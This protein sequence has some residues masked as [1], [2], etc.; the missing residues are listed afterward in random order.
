MANFLTSVLNAGIQHDMPDYL[1][2]RVKPTNI[3]CLVVISV[4][5]IPFTIISLVYFPL[6]AIFPSGAG[7]V[8]ILI[9]V[10]NRLG[11]I[12][13][14]RAVLPIL[15]LILSSL[16]N[17][18]F[19]TSMDDAITSVYLVE[20]SFVLIPFIV[21]DF[22]EKGF[23]IVCNLF[24]LFII[25][26]FPL[27]WEY[28]DMGYDGTVL[29]EGP[30][31]YL[32]IG[33]ATFSQIGSITGLAVLNRQ[34]ESRSTELFNEV[35]KEK[36]EALQSRKELESNLKQLE[37]ARIE[38]NNRQWAAEGIA[39]LSETLRSHGEEK[40]IYDKVIAMIVKYV[41]A[42]QGGLY[43]AD[44]TDS[45]EVS[46][47]LA[48]CYAYERKK[49]IEQ[50]FS[51][52]QG[53]LGQAYL[54]KEYIYLTEI[55]QNYIT[56]T[57]GLGEARP[58]SLLVMPLKVNDKIEGM[59]ELASFKKFEPYQISFIEKLAENL[60]GFIQSNRIN[61]QTKKLLEISQQ[62]AEEMRATEEEMRQ[63]MEEL[64]ATQEE[65]KRKSAEMEGQIMAIDAALA[66]IEF[67]L[68]GTVIRANEKFLQ[69]MGY[70]LG[71]IQGKHH[72]MFIDAAYAQSEEYQQFWQHLNE[73]KSQIGD[74]MRISKK[75]TQ[76]WLKAS[77]SPAYDVHGQ[78]Y[79]IVKFAQD[80]TEQRKL[81]QEVD[82]RSEQMSR[83]ISEIEAQTN[84]VN[85]VAIVSK[86]DLQGNI[87]YVNEEFL[88][89]S[90]YTREEVM[91]RNHRFLK[92]GEQDDKLFEELWKTISSG[93]IFRG[94]I[95][96]KAKDG[97]F[98]WVDAIIAPV[99]DENGKPKEYIA[100]RFV[101]NEV[102]E[103]EA[104]VAKAM[105][106]M[107]RAQEEMKLLGAEMQAQNA[108]INNIAIVSKTDLQ[109][110]ITYVNDEFLKWSKYTLQ[111]VIGKNH[112]IL[113][114]GDQ[115]D[116]IFEELWKTISSGKTF[117]GEIKN[118]AKDGSFYWVDAI[119]APIFDE[120]GKPKEYIAQRFVINEAKEKEAVVKAQTSIINSI[121]IVSKTD[122]QGNIT[123]VNDEF[124]KWSKYTLQE[125]IGKNHRILK[126]GDQ[127]DA[128]FEELWKTI[129]SGKIFRGQIKNKA[130]DGTFYWVD[131]I[132]APVLDE[133][134][135]PKEYIA[136]RFVI[137]EVK[138]KEIH[139]AQ[140]ME[141]AQV[142]EKEIREHLQSMQAGREQ[143]VI[144][145]NARGEIE[146]INEE[147]IKMT[148][149]ELA[150]LAGKRPGDV[151]QGPDTDPQ[152]IAN[153]R[154]ALEKRAV[155]KGKIINYSK[156]G[157]PLICH[158]TL[159]PVMNAMGKVD[160]FVSTA[161][162]IELATMESFEIRDN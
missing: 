156:A 32:A 44:T 154:K 91:G 45:G 39:K 53:L 80:T 29:R 52:G 26:I 144:L 155:F 150:D 54:E 21:F 98:Y 25:L 10:V 146:W 46:I 3:L 125:V 96:N 109:G 66:T 79:K 161:T 6:M 23:L 111:E 31:A 113:K 18:F 68:D 92:S 100:Q 78:L 114:S 16:Y 129:S 62:Q 137:N 72:R 128:I 118:K 121:A 117:R 148:G 33:L 2:N 42:N 13:Y 37:K 9:M 157:Q 159:S 106:Q 130:K 7:L 77:Y 126:S 22:S 104:Q 139:L 145:T 27:S 65:V 135:K 20:L 116:A 12:Y 162:F 1:K 94:E 63:N 108:I 131:A 134:G 119:I 110:N 103:K 15:L 76:I 141:Q 142:L 122:L 61:E 41:G 47:R 30:I 28:F 85:S 4:L 149:Y 35:N 40:M 48:A 38:E 136:Q 74:F 19:S 105:V 34:S 140:A 120:N 152:D 153:I 5:S 158:M 84:I 70:S 73:G 14:T 11:G 81:K 43:V 138:E 97:T 127:D 86:T 99:L 87:T 55:P 58:T 60:A 115:D 102:K 124:L 95:K 143:A 123:Y 67:N 132:I 59:L 90:K 56:I 112:R 160:K 57:S 64:E 88:K 50:S 36:A 71:E 93:K 24:S 75:R 101:I 147:F 107:Q 151:L 82:Q 133:K 49:F 69:V 89:W 83:I 51:P 17:A 8:C